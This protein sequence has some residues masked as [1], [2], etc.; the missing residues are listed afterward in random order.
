[1]RKRGFLLPLNWKRQQGNGALGLCSEFLASPARIP[2]GLLSIKPDVGHTELFPAIGG[3]KDF[4]KT[5]PCR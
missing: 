3:F 2:L 5:H 4:Y 1:M